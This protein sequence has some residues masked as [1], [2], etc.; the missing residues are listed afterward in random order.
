[1]QVNN[2]LWQ[3]KI[4]RIL[5]TE[6]FYLFPV[7]PKTTV[8]IFPNKIVGFVFVRDRQSIFMSW[9][10]YA[11]SIYVNLKFKTDGFRFLSM[12]EAIQKFSSEIAVKYNTP[13]I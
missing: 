1:M 3:Q 4:T 9:C 8:I 11:S 6:C 2:L 7:I 5:C 10:W 13:D 12:Y